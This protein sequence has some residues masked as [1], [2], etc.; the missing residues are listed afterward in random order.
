M[1]DVP[2]EGSFAMLYNLAN[3]LGDEYFENV[4]TSGLVMMRF[5]NSSWKDLASGKTILHLFPKNLR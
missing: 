1:L 5:E 4:P 2:K 3:T